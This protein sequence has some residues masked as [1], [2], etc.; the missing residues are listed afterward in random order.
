VPVT[1]G[2]FFGFGEW[3]GVGEGG[4]GDG[5]VPEPEPTPRVPDGAGNARS[6]STMPPT[7]SATIIANRRVL[8]ATER[9]RLLFDSGP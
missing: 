6:I 1:V 3:P 2:V 7:T 5:E 9:Y 8:V 4:E